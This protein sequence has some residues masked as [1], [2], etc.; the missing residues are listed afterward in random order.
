MEVEAFEGDMDQAKPLDEMASFY[1][2]E[3]KSIGLKDA[4]FTYYPASEE[5]GEQSKDAMPMVLHDLSLE[6]KKG[7][8]VIC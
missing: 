8:I 1:E 2:S 5:V 6:I 3:L 4:S 7:E